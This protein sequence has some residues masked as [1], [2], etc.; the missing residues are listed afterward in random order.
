ML[1]VDTIKGKIGEAVTRMES[2]LTMRQSIDREMAGIEH[3]INAFKEL[4]GQEE[5]EKLVEEIKQERE[6]QE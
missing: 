6:K 3:T 1:T 5:F 4:I 2:L